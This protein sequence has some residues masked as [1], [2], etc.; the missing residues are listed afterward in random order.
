MEN[1]SSNPKTSTGLSQNIAA[2][3]SYL[4]GFVTGII[5][6][7][8]EK[9]NRFVRFHAM[10]S[11]ITFLALFIISFIA[12]LIPFIGTMLSSLIGIIQF[13]VWIVLMYKAYKNEMFKLPITG[14]MAEQQISKQ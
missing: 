14:D 9:D 7:L 13:I 10:Q 4:L 6:L 5:F 11:L 3:L 8:I 2:L 1:G 12:G